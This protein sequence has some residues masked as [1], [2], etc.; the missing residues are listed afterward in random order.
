MFT[1]D[2]IRHPDLE[3][4]FFDHL[5][6]HSDLALQA[7]PNLLISVPLSDQK[8]KS[9]HLLASVLP[10]LV[11]H[12]CFYRS[13]S[14]PCRK[15]TPKTLASE[16]L[17][18]QSPRVFRLNKTTRSTGVAELEDSD[19]MEELGRKYLKKDFLRDFVRVR[20]FCPLLVKP[21]RDR[22]ARL[23]SFRFS[24]ALQPFPARSNLLL[25][26]VLSAFSS[27]VSLV[28]WRSFLS[29]PYTRSFRLLW[30]RLTKC[31]AHPELLLALFFQ[32]L[33]YLSPFLPHS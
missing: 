17:I 26:P 20:I 2:S 24:V 31:S 18:N 4:P 10:L 16:L 13:L 6:D 11:C 21:S 5:A 3:T 23:L 8:S 28:F 15:L 29:R 7:I 9:K 22:H 32:L 1:P 33:L 25:A 12:Q 27:H 30:N 14:N 19:H